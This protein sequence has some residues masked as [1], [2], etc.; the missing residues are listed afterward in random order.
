MA[1][2]E[3]KMDGER[4]VIAVID[5]GVEISSIPDIIDYDNLFEYQR[6]FLAELI[7]DSLTKDLEHEILSGTT[8]TC[9]IVGTSPGRIYTDG[10]YD[11]M[12][13]IADIPDAEEKLNGIEIDY[14]LH[15][16][17]LKEPDY[18]F[19]NTT[20]WGSPKQSARGVFNEN[21]RKRKKHKR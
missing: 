2:L 6:D 10:M 12:T 18:F 19:K 14:M 16:P 7:V 11:L 8:S 4:V 1:K 15:E 13:C 17:I 3:K 21:A 5:K 9:S 20:F